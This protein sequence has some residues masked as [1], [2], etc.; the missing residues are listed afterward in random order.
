MTAEEWRRAF[1]SL[2]E[3]TL[4]ELGRFVESRRAAGRRELEE[5]DRKWK[6]RT[7]KKGES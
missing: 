6:D 5:F 3:P 1:A 4:E 2:P 7:V